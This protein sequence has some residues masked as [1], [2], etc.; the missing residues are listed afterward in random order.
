ML[1]FVAGCTSN[2]SETAGPV[3]G[4]PAEDSTPQQEITLSNLLA[5]NSDLSLDGA[6]V[7]VAPITMA[8]PNLSKIIYIKNTS[9][10]AQALDIKILNS[11][12]LVIAINRC[13]ASLPA[14]GSC[15]IKISQSD[16]EV[17]NGV[18]TGTLQVQ[19]GLGVA[20]SSTIS[21]STWVAPSSD[22]SVVSD[23]SITTTVFD[24]AA[25][26]QRLTKKCVLKNNS[27]SKSLSSLAYSIPSG[28][29]I[30][31]SRCGESIAPG[32][33]CDMYIVYD[34]GGAT[35]NVDDTISVSNG[36]ET[37]A[38]QLITKPVL[39]GIT[40]SSDKKTINVAGSHLALVKS[41]KIMNGATLVNSL[42]ISSKTDSALVLKP[43][44]NIT[45]SSQEYTLRLE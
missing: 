21:G 30:L 25:S 45:V 9:A 27:S 6:G 18:Q 20:V 42:E 17:P 1:L 43:T 36:S 19:T 2:K 31:L 4:T 15:S 11:T 33:S 44:A 5:L 35:P 12:K 3:A 16:R 38:A 24:E 22:A 39:S 40:I 37:Q 13:P 23:L 14:S 34:A 29:R 26:G 28:Y 41:A 7:A 32:R 10:S 8:S